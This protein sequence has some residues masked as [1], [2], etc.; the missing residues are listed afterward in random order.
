MRIRPSG[1]ALTLAFMSKGTRIPFF[2]DAL[3]TKL[4]V[5]IDRDLQAPHVRSAL[6]SARAMIAFSEARSTATSP[7]STVT[8]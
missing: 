4:S 7:V 3:L 6:F 8:L 2:D 5:V 1:V